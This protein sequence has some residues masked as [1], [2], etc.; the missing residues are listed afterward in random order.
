M[1]IFKVLVIHQTKK[2]QTRGYQ[3]NT[4]SQ[5]PP[6]LTILLLPPCWRFS[7]PL[8]PVDDNIPDFLTDV[9][10]VV[11]FNK[12]IFLKQ[13]NLSNTEYITKCT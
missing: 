5:L 4:H 10:V 12:Q 6:L 9:F 2:R 8:F 11:V 7:Q 13:F 1:V 3:M